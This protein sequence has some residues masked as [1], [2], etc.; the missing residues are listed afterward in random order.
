MMFCFGNCICP[1]R[2]LSIWEKQKKEKRKCRWSA[3]VP[4]ATGQERCSSHLSTWCIPTLVFAYAPSL[5]TCW[6]YHPLLSRLHH[7]LLLMQYINFHFQKK[8]S[9]KHLKWEF[10][11]LFCLFNFLND[12]REQ[13]NHFT[14]K[15]TVVVEKQEVDEY[16]C[17]EYNNNNTKTVRRRGRKLT[18]CIDWF[19]IY[20]LRSMPSIT[21]W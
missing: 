13:K 19:R 14:Q 21:T 18:T 17:Q 7:L 16:L 5:Q 3:G 15:K 8:N 4:T 2:N 1:K 6:W 11:Y 9:N 10:N 12:S 20:R